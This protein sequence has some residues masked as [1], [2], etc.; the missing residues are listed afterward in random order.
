LY[1]K[2]AA[3]SESADALV[4][5]G[6]ASLEQGP[7]LA[8]KAFSQF[9]KAATKGHVGGTYHMGMCYLKGLVCM[10]SN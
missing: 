3:K 4:K 5:L 10:R 1:Y 7:L 6:Q 8:Q 9:Q 2:E